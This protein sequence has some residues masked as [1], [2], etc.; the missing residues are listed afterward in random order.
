MSIRT[1]DDLKHAQ[2]LATT[3]QTLAIIAMIM[4][5]IAIITK[6]G[7]VIAGKLFSPD[8]SW[9]DGIQ[10]IGLVLI[11]LIPAFLFIEAINHLRRA[12]TKFGKGEFFSVAVSR[13]VAESGSYA[14]YAMIA[15]MAITPNLTRWVSH[16]GGFDLRIEPEYIGMLAFAVF[17]CAVGKILAV[18]TDIKS[19]NDAFV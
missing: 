12:L 2:N 1:A 13:H 16:Q 17:V 15:V 9:R 14:I 11:E 5:I 4:L 3:A 10:G 19:E 7:F 18:A 8:I 6:G